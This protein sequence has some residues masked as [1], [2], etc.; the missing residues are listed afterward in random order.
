M[1]NTSNTTQSSTTNSSQQGTSSSQA[2]TSQ[3]G[4]NNSTT[5]V[6]QNTSQQSRS[7]P[8][9]AAMDILKR[10]SSGSIGA[11]Q[12]QQYMNPYQQ[13][14]INATV[15]QQQANNAVQQNALRG[16]TIGQ[17]ALGGSRAKIAQAELM[18][19][20]GLN[21]ATTIANLNNTAYT[22]A[23]QAAQA[24]RTA[25]LQA[26]GMMG[27]ETSGT[28]SMTGTNTTAGTSSLV[29]TQDTT[30]Q[31]QS[32]GTSSTNGSANTTTGPGGGWGTVAAVLGM[33]KDGGAVHRLDGGGV[34][35]LQPMTI[36]TLNLGAPPAIVPA[37]THS[38]PKLG[39]HARKKLNSMMD[40]LD[41]P[42]GKTTGGGSGAPA[43]GGGGSGS[44]MSIGSAGAQS[45]AG[46]LAG[47]G[48]AGEGAAAAGEGAGAAGEGAA[49]AGEGAGAAG[50]GA[51]AAGE[52]GA[53][54]LEGV[55][56]AL[57]ALFSDR[58]LK[59]NI[60]QVGKLNDG[61]QVYSY[62][63]KGDPATRIGLM[64]QEVEKRHPEAVGNVNGAKTVRY[65]LATADAVKHRLDGGGIAAGISDT[66]DAPQ[67][68]RAEREREARAAAQ[69]VEAAAREAAAQTQEGPTLTRPGENAG[70]TGLSRLQ[71]WWRGAVERSQPSYTAPSPTPV[72]NPA[73]QETTATPA[74][75]P[76]LG[77]LATPVQAPVPQEIPQAPVST[78][79]VG[80]DG[81]E[82]PKSVLSPALGAPTPIGSDVAPPP[83]AVAEP[84]TGVSDNG[85]DFLKQHEG[86]TSKP[87]WDNKQVSIGYG[88]QAKPGETFIDTEEAERRMRVEAGTVSNYLIKNAAVPLTQGQHDALVSFGYNLGTGKGGLADIMPFIN[89]GDFQGAA[90]KMSRYNHETVNGE[91]RVSNGLTT[92]R[93]DEA[94]MLLGGEAPSGGGRQP[95]EPQAGASPPTPTPGGM[96]AGLAAPQTAEPFRLKGS[97]GALIDKLQGRPAAPAAAAD[98][99]RGGVLKRLLGIDFNP[100]GLNQAERMGL[101]A[102]GLGGVGQGV[103]AYQAQMGSELDRQKLAQQAQQNAAHLA[104]QQEQVNQAKQS[105]G[106]IGQNSD[107][108]PRY[109]FIDSAANTI[110]PANEV[111]GTPATKQSGLQGEEHLATLDPYIAEQARRVG[112][113]L[114]KMPTPSKYN[115]TAKPVADAVRTA[116]P[117]FNEG[118]YD[119]IQKWNDPDK[120]MSKN[121]KAA[122]TFYQHA[123]KLYDLADKLP[124]SGSGRFLNTGKLWFRNQTNDPDLSAYID[125]SK[126]VVDEKIK[127]ITGASPT[128]SERDEL[129]KDYD[130][131]KGRE[132]IRRVLAED[133]HL[134]EGRSKSV[135]SDYN[136]H[137]PRNAPK[138]DVFD[139]ESKKVMARLKGES[140]QNPAVKRPA[141]MSNTDLIKRAQAEIDTAVS[142]GADRTAAT[143]YAQDYLRQV[144]AL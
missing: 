121:I 43:G 54:A 123:G 116:Y 51:T 115:P 6:N 90:E 55:G 99:D 73:P 82:I 87:F 52:G 83:G 26:A 126:Q 33:F 34:N 80:P 31:Y 81:R 66:E 64:A 122:N 44:P 120:G 12:I 14:V 137:I 41:Q 85:V 143:K 65:D 129:L 75:Q 72:A 22:Q 118:S 77:A 7:G 36:P 27:T 62:N 37:Q 144:G 124:S 100:L 71:D 20:Q 56:D 5:N 127:A 141:G 108:T 125:V 3:Y 53:A 18:R 19:G 131:A 101:I 130:P 30:G 47:E 142:K 70:S 78:F 11:D 10:Y 135:E 112:Q 4:T 113:G 48:A 95:L 46:A 39:E 114:A 102:G 68:L 8:I 67:W 134:I 92:R 16:N 98:T 133:S 40:K 59:T 110:K 111:L 96:A 21:D 106:V 89:R 97:V 15:G 91:R 38:M 84:A 50:E 136:K 117:D 63:Y 140:N 76:G 58:R 107:G 93:R 25:A 61:Q 2:N 88:T 138:L 74:A 42:G 57:A 109:G 139:E 28:G 94:A 29:G 128:V 132:T 69:Q 79:R 32:S 45:Q 23:L 105:F 9:Q 17:N 103:Q 13:Q 24:D 104:L 119:F 86:F 1:T 60:H 49:A 35:Y